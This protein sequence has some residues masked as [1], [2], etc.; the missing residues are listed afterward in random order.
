M[1]RRPALLSSLG[2]VT[3][4]SLSVA[5]GGSV[6]ESDPNVEQGGSAGSSAGAAGSHQDAG[7]HAGTGGS[8]WGGA[9]G[10]GTGGWAG[11][12][13]AGAGGA[14]IDAGPDVTPSCVQTHEQF[15]M[16]ASL[17]TGQQIGCTVGTTNGVLELQ[18]RVESSSGTSFVIDS[19]PPNA[20]CGQQLSTFS[21]DAPNLYAYI[22]QGALVTVRVQVDQP[23]GCTQQI[24]VTNLGTWYGTDNPYSSSNDTIY[25]SAS[26]G[27]AQPVSGSK[28]GVHK[29]ALG[30][31]NPPPPSCGGDPPDMYVL[32]FAWLY[33]SSLGAPVYMGQE[34]YFEIP[35]GNGMQYLQA[36]NLRSYSSGACDAYWDWSFWVS[37]MMYE[38]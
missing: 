7:S 34:G 26:D 18:G 3:L 15:M 1:L 19:C 10:A 35:D 22:P 4:I 32:H 8:G 17:H 16:K 11:T 13:G 29:S 24:E 27:T 12:G 33:Q 6:I 14:P 37:Q 36:R 30:C 2:L 20:N 5:C 38:L 28:L 25:L 21:F 9:A 23:W 31:F